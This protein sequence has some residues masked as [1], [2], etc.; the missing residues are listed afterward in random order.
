MFLQLKINYKKNLK[1]N[2]NMKIQEISL[3]N[4]R[5]FRGSHKLELD[6]SNKK[7]FNIILGNNG[8]GKTSTYRALNWCLFSDEP[9]LKSSQKNFS[10]HR[11][12]FKTSID[13]K[14]G[15]T[16]SVSVKLKLI[17]SKNEIINIERT[18]YYKKVAEKTSSSPVELKKLISD[19]ELTISYY[20][21]NGLKELE[22]DQA[23]QFLES[24]IIN[25][26]IKDFFFFD[27][28]DIQESVT[29]NN[30]STI[31][32]H[33]D[34]LTSITDMQ[35]VLR[36]LNSLRKDL[37]KKVPKSSSGDLEGI[38]ADK[39]LKRN[40]LHKKTQ[41][42]T[43]SLE[44]L[45]KSIDDL[46]SE[47]K[48]YEKIISKN[49]ATK[50][51]LIMRDNLD[52]KIQ[53]LRMEYEKIDESNKSDIIGSFASIALRSEIDMFDTLI[54]KKLDAEEL[55]PP[56]LEDS[57][58]ILNF[59]IN[60]NKIT[61]HDN[62]YADIKWK[63][64]FSKEKFIEE[65]ANY[66]EETITKR[67][68]QLAKIAV[69][70]QKYS[71]ALLQT[72]PQDIFVGAQDSHKRLKEIDK[73]IKKL[74]SE[75]VSL[76]NQIG[77]FDN[78]KFKETKNLLV[79]A[80]RQLK[81]KT[82][83]LADAN[84]EIS[85]NIEH[86]K[87]ENEEIKKLEKQ[88]GKSS[89]VL[90]QIRFID[91]CINLLTP[92]IEETRAEVLSITNKRFKKL[93]ENTSLKGKFF[94][95]NI[96]NTYNLSVKD[97]NNNDILANLSTGEQ[98]LVGYSYLQAMQEGLEIKFP[99]LIDTPLSAIGKEMRNGI[100]QNFIDLINKN[101]QMTF[102]FTNAELTPDIF[103]LIKGYTSNFY[104]IKISEVDD[105]NAIDSLYERKKI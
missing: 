67:K 47:I 25:K 22:D 63:R 4:F 54:Q 8:F 11:L 74:E 29:R 12:N 60:D 96:S 28:Q 77:E 43:D 65:I 93:V 16:E 58:D 62:A 56:T 13:M 55:P 45:E 83:E 30:S 3:S 100:M 44:R 35:G 105:G 82:W 49:Q 5:Q 10:S 64:G 79:N 59:I 34:I 6:T 91:E 19:E 78:K 71:S 2:L 14:V 38:I 92:A 86:I 88:S 85:S 9:R 53:V 95:V 73:I 102:F 101:I 66:N 61:L 90:T 40:I 42:R 32:N 15:E 97:N 36:N 7:P 103:N 81:Q 99:I 18:E 89:A 1:E 70:T 46:N 23:E 26:S 39:I 33:L 31:S 24:R 50:E 17:D 41:V 75:R 21:S 72:E 52:T 51:L 37:L 68:S 76:V 87:R 80:E 98:F 27:G 20:D 48:D 84:G 104:E 69:N 57:N 94:D